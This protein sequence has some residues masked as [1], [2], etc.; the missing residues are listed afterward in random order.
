MERP[1][2]AWATH[3]TLGQHR[4][5]HW[6]HL[7]CP[8]PTPPLLWGQRSSDRQHTQ[9]RRL[10]SPLAARVLLLF[11]AFLLFL[12]STVDNL[13]NTTIAW[14]IPLDHNALLPQH[15]Q[16]GPATKHNILCCSASIS[17]ALIHLNA[18]P[19]RPW[20]NLNMAQNISLQP[21]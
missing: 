1:T 4:A 15:G 11:V 3:H 6:T 14:R 7:I 12:P 17:C 9:A 10:T 2:W 21:H 13:L 18:A 19:I 8:P 5:T 20:Y 16:S